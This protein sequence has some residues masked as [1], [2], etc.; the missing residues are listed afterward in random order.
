MYKNTPQLAYQRATKQ[1]SSSLDIYSR[2]TERKR[3]REMALSVQI[4]KEY[5]YVVLDLVAYAFLN[6]WMALQ[7]GKARTKYSVHPLLSCISFCF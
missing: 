1:N 2:L 4:P 5:G 7:V 6:T 3:E